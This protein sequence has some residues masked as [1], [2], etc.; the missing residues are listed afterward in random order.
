MEQHIAR[1]EQWLNRLS[2]RVSS[3]STDGYINQYVK[4]QSTDPEVM[5]AFLRVNKISL[6]R[7]IARID[8][9]KPNG[10]LLVSTDSIHPEI[11]RPEGGWQPGI[12]Y[13]DD[14][15]PKLGPNLLVESEH[16]GSQ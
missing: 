15:Y 2:N 8:I 10:E 5:A 11:H 12:Y 7:S 1:I 3:Y 13:D 6:D 4:E 14:C 9:I 16:A